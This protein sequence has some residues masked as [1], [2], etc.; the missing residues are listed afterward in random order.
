MKIKH[1]RTLIAVN[2]GLALLLSMFMVSSPVNATTYSLSMSSSM[3]NEELQGIGNLSPQEACTFSISNNELHV[4]PW[5][6]GEYAARYQYSQ[7]FN[8][9]SGT[10]SGY[11]YTE[12]TMDGQAQVAVYFKNSSGTIKYKYKYQLEN[13]DGW[14]AFSFPIRRGSA[15][16]TKVQV[17]FGNSCKNAGVVHF[18][19]LQVSDTS[20]S[21]SFPQNYPTLTRA[22]APDDLTSTNEWRIEERNDT[23]WLVKPDGEAFYTLGIDLP[24]DYSLISQSIDLLQDMSFNTIGGW[25]DI[26]DIAPI[27]DQKSAPAPA[28]IAIENG[29]MPGTF[30]KVVSAQGE[31]PDGHTMPDPFDPRWEQALKATITTYKNATYG[32]DW[33]IGYFADNEISHYDLYRRVYSTYCSQAFKSWLMSEYNNGISS[34]NN[35]WGTSY[36]SFDALIAAK[37]DPIKRSGAMYEDFNAFKRVLVQ[38][39][40]D[41]TKD[42]FNEV[43]NNNPP[44][45]FSNRFT[46]DLSDVYDVLDIYAAAF[47]GIGFN[48]YPGGLQVGLPEY[49]INEI[50]DLHEITGKPIIISEWSVPAL[51][52]GLYDDWSNL[53]FSF[54][55]CVDTQTERARQAAYITAQFYNMPYVVGSHWFIWSDLDNSRSANRGIFQSDNVTPWTQLK[56]SITSVQ[57]AMVAAMEGGG[58]ASSQINPSADAYVRGGTSY[59]NTNYGTDTILS[60]KDSSVVTYDRRSYIK[61]Q[62]PSNGYTSCT[63]ATLKVYCRLMPNGAPATVK[64]YSVLDDTWTESGIKWTNMPAVSTLLDSVS[65][66]GTGIEYSFDVTSFVSAQLSGDKAVSICLLD[67][68]L[69]NKDVQLDSREGS[70][71]PVLEINY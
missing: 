14:T 56:N 33:F 50:Q 7:D 70:I 3:W 52:S 10:V 65:I 69:Y 28:M 64:A 23:W 68:A 40:V 60:V 21:I 24:Y 48:C 9:V 1:L 67:N 12:D 44:L 49:M 62:L 36:S 32:K 15:D 20:W 46:V 39:Y 61:F 51:D 26:L 18:K 55:E 35:S 54:P 8:F 16:S 34:L 25:S 6:A 11:Y 57:E 4:G 13:A 29:T 5:L 53:D 37:P 42:A 38:Q 59:E 41:V 30:D 17:A 58:G 22:S 47:D 45:I 27:N 43:Y 71:M 19:N 31:A 2:L 66:T 63:S